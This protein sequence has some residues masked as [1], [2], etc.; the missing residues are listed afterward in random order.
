ML[1]SV[2]SY[3]LLIKHKLLYRIPNTT[4]S[5]F[6]GIGRYYIWW[7]NEKWFYSYLLLLL[8][9][10]CSTWSFFSA[11]VLLISI[12]H[13][14]MGSMGEKAPLNLFLKPFFFLITTL[15]SI[16]V[17]GMFSGPFGLTILSSKSTWSAYVIVTFGTPFGIDVVPPWLLTFEA[18]EI[19]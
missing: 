15:V 1:G 3:Y 18:D 12:L 10:S 7:H 19:T 13:S 2:L 6:F 17:L 16:L 14:S 5:N 8:L 9:S 4:S 11:L